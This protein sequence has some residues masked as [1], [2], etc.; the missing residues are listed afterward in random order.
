MEKQIFSNTNVLEWLRYFSENTD[1]DLE[2][3]KILDITKKNKDNHINE[4]SAAVDA[5][6]VGSGAGI[7]KRL[8]KSVIQGAG[9]LLS[10]VVLYAFGTAWF[11]ISTGTPVGAALSLCVIPFIPADLIKIVIAAILGPTLAGITKKLRI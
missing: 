7:K 4:S 2:H 10:V 6:A 3:V 9:M 1:L 11:V 8:I 5:V